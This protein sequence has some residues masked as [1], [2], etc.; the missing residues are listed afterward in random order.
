M[1]LRGYWLLNIQSQI[2]Y[3]CWLSFEAVYLYFFIIETKNRTLEETA[4]LF[5][6]DDAL[7]QITGAAAHE[8]GISICGSKNPKTL[9]EDV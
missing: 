7:E 2:V 9:D 6:G 4:A 1:L 3:V 8:A 5:D